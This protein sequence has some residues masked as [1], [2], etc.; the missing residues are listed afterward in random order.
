MEL[1]LKLALKLAEKLDVEMVAGI[2]AE[3]LGKSRVLRVSKASLPTTVPAAPRA[4]LFSQIQ[5]WSAHDM[6]TFLYYALP[7][8]RS[9]TRSSSGPTSFSLFF[10]AILPLASPQRCELKDQLGVVRLVRYS[11]S[12][13]TCYRVMEGMSARAAPVEGLRRGCNAPGCEVV[14]PQR[15]PKNS[16]SR[17]RSWL[18][19]V[20]FRLHK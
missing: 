2:S 20:G 15:A 1:A 12:Y 11:R 7:R 10:P 19:V 8:G 18:L 4:V 14:V 17:S 16:R 5:Q 3:M 6:D 13:E 9:R